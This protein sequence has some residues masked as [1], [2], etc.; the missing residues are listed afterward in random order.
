MAKAAMKSAW[1]VEEFS[2]PEGPEAPERGF[3]SYWPFGEDS[4]TAESA[5]G[6]EST[7]SAFP[8]ELNGTSIDELVAQAKRRGFLDGREEGIEEGWAQERERQHAVQEAASRAA[9]EK[10]N[11]E[12]ARL[13]ANLDE[14]RQQYLHEIEP[15]VVRLALGI[16]ARILRREAQMDPLLLSGAVRVALGQLAASTRVRLKVPESDL[17]LW[18]EAIALLPN[19][20]TR[21]EVIAGEGM[22]LGDCII[23][24]ELGSVDL[25][26]RAQLNEIERG[27][28]DRPGS[29]SASK[30][31]EHA[32]SEATQ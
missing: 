9:A 17:A 8:E 13:I 18:T 12:R 27:F 25:G 16:A 3:D 30:T 15:E 26:V 19:P 10:L 31:R 32:P 4:S 21:P 14:A 1:I 11:A 2:Y 22:R 20:G 24:T 23:E 7:A 5:P 28:F 29:P 6:E